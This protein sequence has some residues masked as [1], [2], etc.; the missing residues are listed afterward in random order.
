MLTREDS[1]MVDFRHTST[2][3]ISRSGKKRSVTPTGLSRRELLLAACAFVVPTVTI[4][5]VF[6]SD[7]ITDAVESVIPIGQKTIHILLTDPT[8]LLVTTARQKAEVLRILKEDQKRLYRPGDRVLVAR[9]T[10]TPHRPDEVIFDDVSPGNA[11]SANPVFETASELE[12]AWSKFAPGFYAAI[13]SGLDPMKHPEQTPLFEAIEDLHSY[14]LRQIGPD[15][16]VRVCIVSDLLVHVDG[17]LSMYLSPGHRQHPLSLHGKASL[18]RKKM[19][20]TRVEFLAIERRG[21]RSRMGQDMFVAQREI[22]D[23]MMEY[24]E[25]RTQNTVGVTW[26]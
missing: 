19:P 12:R 23:W 5:A 25:E 6:G 8:D 24:F 14:A 11:D 13:E 1:S 2:T 10:K 22:S 18:E 7:I 3:A 15:D 17:G 4:T 26:L 21:L 20:N 9:L 16:R